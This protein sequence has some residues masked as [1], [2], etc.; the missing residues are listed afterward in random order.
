MK[1][2]VSQIVVAALLLTTMGFAKDKKKNLLP[3]YVL[4]AQ[5]VAVV[6]DPEAGMSVEDPQ[7]NRVAQ[8]DV[9]T[10]LLNWGRFTPVMA[11]QSADLIIVV[12]RGHGKLVDETINSPRQNGR[13]GVINPTDNGVMVGAQHG[14]QPQLSGASPSSAEEQSSP[15]TEIGGSDDSFLVYRGNTENPLD[16]APAWRYIARD[17]LRPHTVPAVGEFRKILAEAEKA[18]AK[19]P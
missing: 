19:K 10:A 3:A 1:K 16:S 2:Q 9:E 5:T 15:Q 8:K 17:G 13:A 4:S 11:T 18:A 12:R 7:A 6:I 14:Q